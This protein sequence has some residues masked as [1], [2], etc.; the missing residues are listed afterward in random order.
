MILGVAIGLV[1]V[2]VGAALLLARH[3]FLRFA[4]RWFRRFYGQPV[5]DTFEHRGEKGVIVGA[6]G[7]IVFGI[8]Q[9]IVTAVG[10]S[11]AGL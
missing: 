2:T 6:A 5:A 11:R 10:H 8:V 3:A 4:L 1:I 9:I 7:S